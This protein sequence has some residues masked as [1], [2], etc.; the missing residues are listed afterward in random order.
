VLRGFPELRR[1]VVIDVGSLAFGEAVNEECSG[2]APEEDDGPV[3]LRS[4]LLGSGDPLLDDL[5]AKARVYLTRFGP[6]DGF[7]QEGVR[8]PRLSGKAL[9]PSGL[10]DS[11]RAIFIL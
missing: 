6:G 4:S 5:A 1:F 7:A 11:H 9:K 10:V 2:P 8:N 3:A